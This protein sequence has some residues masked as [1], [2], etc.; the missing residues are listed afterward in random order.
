MTLS[1]LSFV[2]FLDPYQAM[3]DVCLLSTLKICGICGIK[4]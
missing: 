2:I 3:N 4:V 1:S